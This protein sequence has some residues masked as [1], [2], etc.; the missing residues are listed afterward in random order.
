M[1][2]LKQLLLDAL[3][4]FK[5]KKFL[6]NYEC[7]QKSIMLTP[8]DIFKNCLIIYE[9][10]INFEISMKNYE[11]A[12][13]LCDRLLA[14]DRNLNEIW[15]QQFYVA[16][17]MNKI[18]EVIEKSLKSCPFDALIHLNIAQYYISIVSIIVWR[19]SLWSRFNFEYFRTTLKTQ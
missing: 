18:K 19:E 9:N 8:K 1:Q 6:V 3:G 16:L 15:L 17:Q 12:F 10:L 14:A 5:T 11:I 4:I 13:K 2:S 7:N